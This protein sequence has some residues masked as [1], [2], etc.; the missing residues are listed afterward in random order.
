M[1]VIVD[2]VFEI[3]MFKKNCCGYYDNGCLNV[4]MFWSKFFVDAEASFSFS[5]SSEYFSIE[6][7]I[8]KDFGN[9]VCKSL[10]VLMIF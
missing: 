7:E 6:Y 10:S 1:W 8:E 2:G 5:A 4:D 3:L 9:N